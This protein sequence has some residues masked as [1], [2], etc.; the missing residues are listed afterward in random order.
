MAMTVSV[1]LTALPGVVSAQDD[2]DAAD[3][4]DETP[5][6]PSLGASA[7]PVVVTASRSSEDLSKTPRAVSIVSGEQIFERIYRTTPE[8]LR[9][10]EGVMVQRTNLGGGAPAI[11]GLM[12]NQVLYLVDGIRVNN[13]TFRGGPNQYL[14]TID[15]FFIDQIEVV[16]GPGSVVYGSDALGGTINV[17]TKHREDFR[18]PFDADA[19]L[20][21]RFSTADAERTAHLSTTMNAG[22]HVGISAA[23]N[24]RA[25][26]D[27]D[28]GGEDEPVQGPYG[29][30][31]DDAAANFDFIFSPKVEWRFSGQLVNQNMVPN[32][33]PDNPKNIYDPQER[34]LAYSKLIFS[35]L[36]DYLDRVELWG[37]FQRQTEGRLKISADDPTFETQDLDEVDTLGAGAQLEMPVGEWVR[38]I[39]GGEYYADAVRSERELEDLVTGDTTEQEAQFPDDSAYS[40]TATYLE[41]RF[42]PLRWMRLV[43]G[44]R[45]TYIQPDITLDDPAVGEITVDDPISDVTWAFHSHW[46]AGAGHG[47]VAG[48][49]RGFRAPNL[50]DLAK[51]GSEDGR[52]DV[53]N[54]ELDPETLIQY[55]AGYRV[56]RKRTFFSLF[57]YYSQIDDLITRKPTTY[58]GDAEIN[59]EEVNQNENVGEA[60]IY[61]AEASTKLTVLEDLF[62]LGGTTTYTFGHN[63]TDDEPLRRIPPWMGTA[64]IKLGGD[65]AWFETAME[66]AAK[67]DRLSQADKDDARIGEDGT[68]SFAV[69]HFRLGMRVN[70]WIEGIAAVENAFDNKYKYHG[71]GPFEPGRN[72]KTQVSFKF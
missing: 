15:P 63:E 66:A 64:W 36:S 48:V 56:T 51:L 46:D 35:D 38:F 61:G 7:E 23:G 47:F 17:I 58:N 29:Y 30:V 9:F 27:I 53:P 37:S 43:P 52:Y 68:P 40:T 65:P 44:V 16:R 2:A 14:N 42:T 5:V 11:R 8:S 21:G 72:F 62:S 54:P 22:K 55:E 1:A 60:I 70:D 33:D 57:G 18:K 20:M 19:R 6:E 34:R 67:Q 10:A 32:Y 13:S 31:Q 39:F 3:E 25:F 71:S 24:T 59:G 12:G 49:S 26:G 50:A 41:A 4:S 45:Y 28:P 69:W